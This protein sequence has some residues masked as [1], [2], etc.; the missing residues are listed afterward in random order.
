[1]SNFWKLKISFLQCINLI[2]IFAS[3]LHTNIEDDSDSTKFVI[4]TFQM[5]SEDSSV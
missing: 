2:I 4:H 1:M 3:A 5:A